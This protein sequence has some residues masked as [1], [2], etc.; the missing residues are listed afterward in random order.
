M[1]KLYA[2]RSLLGNIALVVFVAF[3]V[4]LTGGFSSPVP[5]NAE[6]PI[7]VQEFTPH[8]TPQQPV[9]IED[10][11]GNWVLPGGTAKIRTTA[12]LRQ[13]SFTIQVLTPDDFNTLEKFTAAVNFKVL[14]LQGS[15]L[16]PRDTN[17]ADIKKWVYNN[18]YH[19]YQLVY[20]W[21][22]GEQLEI[23]GSPNY[24]FLVATN[25]T[26]LASIYLDLEAPPPE[27]GGGGGGAPPMPPRPAPLPTEG[28][29]ITVEGPGKAILTADAAKIDEILG[30]PGVHTIALVLDKDVAGEEGTIEIGAEILEKIFNKGMNLLCDIAG[31]TVL[32]KPG[33][34]DAALFAT[35]KANV[36]LTVSSSGTAPPGDSSYRVAGRITDIT[37]RAF[38]DGTDRGAVHFNKP[39]ELGIPYDPSLLGGVEEEHLAVYRFNTASG[40]WEPVRGSRVDRS[41]GQVTC[42]RTSLSAYAAMAYYKSFADV[43]GHWAQADV[44]LLASR[45]IIAGVGLNR[46][47]PEKTVTRAEF[48]AMA[49][50]LLGLETGQAG[51]LFKDVPAGAWYAGVV[52]TAEEAGLVKGY[53]DGTFRPEAPVTRQEIAAV[54][55]RVLESEGKMPTLTGSEV[56]DILSRFRDRAQIG[57]WAQTAIAAAVK[58]GIITGRQADTFAPR[59]LATRAEAAAMLKRVLNRLET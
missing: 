21:R 5:A 37:C 26:V 6:Q 15:E 10:R 53:T 56:Q 55:V 7:P 17:I 29:F 41:A 36:R 11:E 18:V 9:A 1:H 44:E 47:A 22:Y 39:V 4:T 57:T 48:A 34:F 33:A 8:V 13:V 43:A 2:N 12:N 35:E 52:G 54:M 14:N 28:G 50:R 23:A 27:G 32:F 24:E 20:F 49:V 58:E 38:S 30:L 40:Q 3:L 46:F 16:A 51:S 19:I 42:R 25:S 45:H 31:T 59:R